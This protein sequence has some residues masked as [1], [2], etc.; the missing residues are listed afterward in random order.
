MP[1]FPSVTWEQEVLTR[2]SDT[3]PKP[4]GTP[5]KG[6]SHQVSRARREGSKAEGTASQGG[7]VCPR[8]AWPGRGRGSAKRA[9][10][11]TVLRL[12]VQGRLEPTGKEVGGWP[13]EKLS[14]LP[15]PL[16]SSVFPAQGPG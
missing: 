15:V 13:W 7:K 9:G 3:Q 6:R 1:V 14:R 10:W 16:P 4:V 8:V 2:G 11:D 5:E 12:R